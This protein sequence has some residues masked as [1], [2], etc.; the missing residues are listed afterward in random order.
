[1]KEEF[2]EFSHLIKWYRTCCTVLA[3]VCRGRAIRYMEALMRTCLFL[4]LFIVFYAT[5]VEAVPLSELVNGGTVTTSNGL[6]FSN[7]QARWSIET[8]PWLRD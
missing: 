8:P 6:T 1:M 5:T 2:Q 4:V 7:F 3:A